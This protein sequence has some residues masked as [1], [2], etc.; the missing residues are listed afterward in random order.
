ME[1]YNLVICHFNAFSPEAGFHDSFSKVVLSGEQTQ[2]VDYPMGGDIWAVMT[3]IEGPAS[4]AGTQATAQVM[5]NSSIGTDPAFRDELYYLIDIF[6]ES[7]FVHAD[8]KNKKIN[9]ASTGL[10][11]LFSPIKFRTHVILHRNDT[12]A[13]KKDYWLTGYVGDAEKGTGLGRVSAKK[14]PWPNPG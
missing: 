9:E 6:K 8:K 13:A 10:R 3:G 1:V 5:G 12:S 4:H 11:S 2:S 7:M 14:V